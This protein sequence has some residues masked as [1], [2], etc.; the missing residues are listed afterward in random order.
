MA[1]P[2]PSVIVLIVCKTVSAGPEDQNSAFTHSENLKWATENSMMVCRRQEI[3]VTDADEAKGAGPQPFNVQ[4]CQRSGFML[5][6]KFDQDHKNGPWRFWRLGC[7]VPIVRQNPDGS[8]EIIAWKI[9]DCGHRETVV[10]ETDT[11]I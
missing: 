10:C 6:A 1:V 5:G 2:M 11:A 4:R 9:P 7:P 3:E 8:E